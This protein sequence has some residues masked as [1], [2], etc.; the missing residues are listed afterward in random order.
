[1]KCHFHP[2]ANAIA[3]CSVCG[4]SLCKRCLIEDRGRT[5]CDNCYAAEQDD[6]ENAELVH[7]EEAAESEDYIDVELMDLLDT[8]DDDGLF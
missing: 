7:A 8:H 3:V 5:Y 1:M 6:N 4:L 2:R